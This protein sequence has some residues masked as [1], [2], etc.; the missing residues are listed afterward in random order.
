MRSSVSL[1]FTVE[2]KPKIDALFDEPTDDVVLIAIE[3]S[4]AGLNLRIAR[5]DFERMIT[6]VDSRRKEYARIKGLSQ[7]SKFVADIRRARSEGRLKER[8][9]PSDLREACPGWADATYSAFPPQY[10]RGNPSGHVPYFDQHE[11]GSY[12]LLEEPVPIASP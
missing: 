10:R 3:D 6:A 7:Q 8:F 12:S 2:R 1:D 5:S 4:Q 9:L 11:D